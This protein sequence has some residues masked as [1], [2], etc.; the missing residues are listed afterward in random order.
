MARAVSWKG[1]KRIFCGKV[2]FSNVPLEALEAALPT[3][4][5]L[6][7]TR[8]DG[9]YQVDYTQGGTLDKLVLIE[10]LCGNQDFLFQGQHRD[11]PEGKEMQGCILD[12]TSTAGN[13]HMTMDHAKWTHSKN[14]SIQQGVLPV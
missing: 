10:H 2:D 11:A 7:E 5:L 8:G 3:V 6:L 9:L 4:Q 1:T 13:M 14:Q 12:N